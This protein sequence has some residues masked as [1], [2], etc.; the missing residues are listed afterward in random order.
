MPVDKVLR[1]S[2]SKQA[3]SQTGTR[4]DEPG[5]LS[6]DFDAL[7]AALH[8]VRAK[9]REVEVC[10]AI[11]R[12]CGLELC[13]FPTSEIAEFARVKDR[14]SILRGINEGIAHGILRGK[15]RP[16][17]AWLLAIARRYGRSVAK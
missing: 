3:N 17:R 2:R 12:R 5:A 1:V 16:G 6:V 8:S 14:K 10:H 13:E 9:E 15:K 4:S 7:D 11:R